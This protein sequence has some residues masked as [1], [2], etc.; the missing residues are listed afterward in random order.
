MK[1][2][3]IPCPPISEQKRIVDYLSDELKQ[4][5]SARASVQAEIENISFD[6]G[7]ER[8]CAIDDAVSD[9]TD[10]NKQNV[11]AELKLGRLSESLESLN[12]LQETFV[13]EIV[14]GKRRA[15]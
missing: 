7:T 14:T 15:M 6:V 3:V 8:R 10:G 1:K 12:K 5:R 9:M 2:I 11:L 13:Y 4:I